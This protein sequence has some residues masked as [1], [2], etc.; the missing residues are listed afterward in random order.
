MRFPSVELRAPGRGRHY[1]AGRGLV[2][3]A[4][5]FA[6][7]GDW[8]AKLWSRV[9]G[10]SEV[11]VVN[12][13]IR[14]EPPRAVPFRVAFASDLHLG[15]TTPS[16]LLDA[17]F[18]K[19]AEAR[20]D[21]LVLGGDYVFLDAT[22]ERARELGA[23]VRAVPAAR[24]VAVMG[25]HDLWTHHGMLE[26]A[27]REAG[28]E[29]L[30]NAS[31]R[32]AP[33]HDD[34][35]VV[36]LDEPWTGRADGARA[37]AGAAGAALTIAVCHA[38]DGLPEIRGRGAALFLSGHTHG[39]QLALPGGVPVLLP[40]GVWARRFPHGVHE[41]EGMTVFVSRGVGGV[42]IPMRVFAPP[43]IGVFDIG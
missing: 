40:G 24:K 37:F 35:A 21:L 41:L 36:G 4:L 16:S 15:P 30:V 17:A 32:L 22:P 11:R 28:V 13:R 8:P 7:A 5:R 1:T 31:T 33:P 34:V 2:E 27:L 23:R 6:Y 14:V 43:D 12:A 18:A 19:L 39:G 29:V 42:E 26:D 9:P 25:N 38:P 10:A 3:S 20:P